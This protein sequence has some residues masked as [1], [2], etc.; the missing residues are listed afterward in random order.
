MLIPVYLTQIG[1]Y[2]FQNSAE[3]ITQLGTAIDDKY[4]YL[5][6]INGF[7]INC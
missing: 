6:P 1:Q 4:L 7:A 3:I 5:S 2:F